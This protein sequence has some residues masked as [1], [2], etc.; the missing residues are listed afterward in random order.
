MGICLFTVADNNLI[1][2][3]REGGG[4]PLSEAW[5]HLF[6]KRHGPRPLYSY[7]CTDLVFYR[8]GWDRVET[9]QPQFHRMEDELVVNMG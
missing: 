1:P 2:M 3:D 9:F 5:A 6:L 8:V 7:L 4:V